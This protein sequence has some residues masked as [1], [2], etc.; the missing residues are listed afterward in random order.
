MEKKEKVQSSSC[1]YPFII[2]ITHAFYT[3][4]NFCETTFF[5]VAKGEIPLSKVCPEGKD[6]TNTG[7]R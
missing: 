4:R 1:L 5:P 6:G 2:F 7:G 3:M